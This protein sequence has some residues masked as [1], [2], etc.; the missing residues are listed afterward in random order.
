MLCCP[1]PARALHLKQHTYDS[2]LEIYR[3]QGIVIGRTVTR[4]PSTQRP[5]TTGQVQLGPCDNLFGRI[6]PCR[7]SSHLLPRTRSV[8]NRRETWGCNLLAPPSS[9]LLCCDSTHFSRFSP[10]VLVFELLSHLCQWK[11]WLLRG[12]R[13]L[14]RA[15]Y[16]A[17]VYSIDRA[18]PAEKSQASQASRPAGTRGNYVTT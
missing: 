14:L 11:P 12:E 8:K 6:T 9:R 10:G 3:C 1:E 16:S 17:R 5:G 15:P 7:R 13:L 2:L 4:K 18:A